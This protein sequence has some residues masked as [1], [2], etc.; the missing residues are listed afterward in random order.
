MHTTITTDIAKRETLSAM[1][2]AY[3]QAT[4][5]VEQAY[6]ILEQAQNTLRAMFLDRPGYR[7]SVNPLCQYV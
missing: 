4:G 7:F 6:D 5:M 1:I 2:G 3:Q